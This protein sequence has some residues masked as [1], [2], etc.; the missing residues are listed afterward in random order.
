MGHGLVSH[1]LQV[2]GKKDRVITRS[3]PLA[4]LLLFQLGSRGFLEGSFTAVLMLG[5]LPLQ[6]GIS[7]RW[8]LSKFQLL[9]G[10]IVSHLLENGEGKRMAL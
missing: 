3:R 9:N 2:P 10:L 7:M 8:Y 6:S 4:S 5:E 1:G